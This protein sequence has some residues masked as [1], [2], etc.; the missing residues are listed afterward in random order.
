[1]K[2]TKVNMYLCVSQKKKTGV[3]APVFLI[4]GYFLSDFQLSS[5]LLTQSPT[6]RAI[7]A[8]INVNMYFMCVS[9]PF[10]EVSD[11]SYYNTTK[12]QSQQKITLQAF[13]RH[14]KSFLL[15]RYKFKPYILRTYKEA[16]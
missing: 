7:T 10:A 14:F 6:K 9:P 8:D 13:K 16:I 5:H 2:S 12:I 3:A 11:K 4:L 15:S 1:M